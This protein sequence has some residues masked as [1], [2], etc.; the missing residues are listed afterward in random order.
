MK[1][2][3]PSP[4]SPKPCKG[5]KDADS[6]VVSPSLD[7][8]DGLGNRASIGHGESQDIAADLFKEM[9]QYSEDDLESRAKAVRWKL[10][11]IIVP[12]VRKRPLSFDPLDF[13]ISCGPL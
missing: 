12:L 11:L 10:D 13:K 4:S 8:K 6:R 1:T 3:I 7:E 5:E 9:L 2:E